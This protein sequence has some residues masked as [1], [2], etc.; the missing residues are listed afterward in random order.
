VPLVQLEIKVV[1][2]KL[3]HKVLLALKETQVQMVL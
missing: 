1:Q 2:E 3:E